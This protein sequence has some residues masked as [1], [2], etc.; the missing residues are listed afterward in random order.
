MAA[1]VRKEKLECTVVGTSRTRVMNWWGLWIGGLPHNCRGK[2]QG[3]TP[4]GHLQCAK[5][6]C[7]N[8]GTSH[9]VFLVS[10]SGTRPRAV[11]IRDGGLLGDWGSTLG[12]DGEQ[13]TGET[14][15]RREGETW[16]KR[17]GEEEEGGEKEADS[18][19]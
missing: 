16:G 11:L 14:G 18:V 13:E 15:W 2:L 9:D 17:K 19:T 7:H 6:G 10:W 3:S 8:G 5:S 1:L 4:D 12:G